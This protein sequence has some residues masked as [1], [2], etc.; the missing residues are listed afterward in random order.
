VGQA[1]RRHVLRYLAARERAG[2]IGTGPFD[3][4]EALVRLDARMNSGCRWAL[5]VTVDVARTGQQPGCVQCEGFKS[6]AALD[7]A[8]PGSVPAN[9]LALPSASGPCQHCDGTGHNV[10]AEASWPAWLRRKGQAMTVQG[11]G[12]FRTRPGSRITGWPLASLLPG[13]AYQAHAF[14]ARCENEGERRVER[15]TRSFPRGTHE[16]HDPW[17]ANIGG[18]TPRALTCSDHLPAWLVG[19]MRHAEQRRERAQ[20]SAGEAERARRAMR[21]RGVEDAA[22]TFHVSRWAREHSIELDPDRGTGRTTRMLEHAAAHNGPVVVIALDA[23]HA[24]GLRRSAELIGADHVEVTFNAAAP[25]F[26]LGRRDALVLWDHAA[27]DAAPI[28]DL[29]FLRSRV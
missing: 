14:S 16:R 15:E 7:E 22:F 19:D 20:R 17:L 21:Q 18:I 26:L 8:R 27:R 3:L 9:L 2:I 28:R 25:R 10:H 4:D 6:L 13:W 24:D 29:D 5:A 11:L 12:D 1:K 23:R